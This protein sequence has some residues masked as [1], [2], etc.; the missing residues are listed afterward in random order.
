MMNTENGG[1][2]GCSKADRNQKGVRKMK[3]RKAWNSIIGAAAWFAAGTFAGSGITQYLTN[4]H[5]PEINLIES[6][7]WYTGLLIQ[8]AVTAAFLLLC[9]TGRLMLE[10]NGAEESGA[11]G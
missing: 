1:T 3:D 11:A 2:E 5:H 4:R 10:R 7:P 9:M 6:A 8:G